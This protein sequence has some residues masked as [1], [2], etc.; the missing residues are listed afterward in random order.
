MTTVPQELEQ[1]VN[2][3]WSTDRQYLLIKGCKTCQTSLKAHGCDNLV[4][5]DYAVYDRDRGVNQ[6]RV[7]SLKAND[8][9]ENGLASPARVLE[10][11][12][13]APAAIPVFVSP[14]HGAN[15]AA[16][17]GIKQL[18]IAPNS[19]KALE[20]FTNENN[21]TIDPTVISSWHGNF[22]S[23]AQAQI[24]GVWFFE[25]DSMDV[26]AR[27]EAE[28]G[29]KIPETM[30]V[31]S[32][33]GRGH[34]Y[35]QQTPESIAMGNISQAYVRGGDW[36]ARVDDQYVVSMSSMNP[37]SGKAYE[38]ISDAPIIPAP[39]W[40]I[41]WLISQ[42]VVK[43]TCTGSDNVQR[44]PSGLIP[45]GYIH[46]YMLTEAGKLRGKGLSVK[47]IEIALL[48][49]V[50]A[51]C[52]PPIDDDKVIQ[53]AHS[54]GQYAPGQNT[55]LL[56]TQKP[57]AQA[58]EIIIPII[59]DPQDSDP[60]FDMPEGVF[61][62]R[63][64]EQ[65]G[66]RYTEYPDPG[67]DDLVS[68]V[69]HKLIEGTSISLA[70][71]RE[72]LKQ[73]VGQAISGWVIHPAY[74]QLSLRGYHANL[75]P[76]FIGKTTGL[77]WA[78]KAGTHILELANTTIKNLFRYKSEQVLVRS[79]S[80]EGTQKRDKNG[81]VT[82]GHPG[83]PRQFLVLTE[84]NLVAS[85]S[86]VFA[87]IFSRLIDLYDQTAADTESVTN[88]DFAAA[89]IEI[90]CSMCFTLA[91]FWKTFGSRGN[92]GSGGL[93]RITLVNPPKNHDYDDRDWER[94]SPEQLQPFGQKLFQRVQILRSG[95]PKLLEE[96]PGAK[97]IRLAATKMLKNAGQI[98]V[99]LIEY[100]V[101]EQMIQAA[102]SHDKLLVM[103]AEQAEYARTWVE[104]QLQ[105]RADCWPPDGD[106]KV[107]SMEHAIRKV[108]SG[109]FVPESALKNA[110]HIYRAGTG[111]NWAYQA[112]KKNLV[113]AGDIKWTANTRKAG[114]AFCPGHC[115]LHPALEQS[116]PDKRDK[117]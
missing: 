64:Y 82:S 55:D 32:R 42:K 1:H 102:M 106:N 30:R 62:T 21:L 53:M 68:L 84:G 77:E 93:G 35:W 51:N 89:G 107:E 14:Q 105:V 94:L 97:A 79:L 13:A 96:E 18:K 50:H 114:K 43:T 88:A 98:G 31:R 72:P 109:H 108:L 101:R 83:N 80:S 38:L 87:P 36:S 65:L 56:L 59:D 19:K 7:D 25:I 41:D 24:G 92:I 66:E 75:G 33:P 104:A 29:Q 22:G 69:S 78:I 10:Q 86:D 44:D 2:A 117:K 71:V 49:I 90:S 28:T 46:G 110:C 60:R 99:R 27:I 85:S 100:F 47:T 15:Y 81:K 12:Q 54:I 11:Q 4:P 16:T 23:I 76:S 61:D 63:V 37:M 52:A 113:A 17:R 95:K 45:H 57:G 58:V 9:K 3:T 20:D 26:Q 91:D 111:G 8:N 116:K 115:S 40:L 39:K 70:Y 112:A 5:I 48:E 74:P 73:M 34:F 103:T 6:T 67:V